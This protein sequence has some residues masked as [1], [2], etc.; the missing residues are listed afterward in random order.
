MRK[1]YARR[2]GTIVL[3]CKFKC[4]EK[5]G[6][7]QILDRNECDHLYR[8]WPKSNI[9]SESSFLLIQ[10]FYCACHLGISLTMD[11]ALCHWEFLITL[12]T[13][14]LCKY[15]MKFNRK[16]IPCQTCQFQVI[17]TMLVKCYRHFTMTT[18]D[19][20][21]YTVQYT[22]LPQNMIGIRSHAG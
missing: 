19:L 2:P 20:C 15:R 22:L 9:P 6:S 11:S 13:W 16:L 10:Y 1:W 14:K 8:I 7:E 18:L 12:R 21:W 3:A 4:C 17:S 5:I